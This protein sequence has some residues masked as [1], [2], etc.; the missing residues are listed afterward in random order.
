MS[1]Q[2]TKLYV[3]IKF[4]DGSCLK[5][6]FELVN[7]KIKYKKE[8]TPK[9]EMTLSYNSIITLKK[10]RGYSPNYISEKASFSQIGM[11]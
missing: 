2:N 5:F 1:I 8:V 4:Y 6:S 7:I 9:K 10:V 11:A 3:P